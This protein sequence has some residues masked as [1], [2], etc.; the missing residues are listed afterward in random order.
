MA[1]AFK[2]YMHLRQFV[3]SWTRRLYDSSTEAESSA[4]GSSPSALRPRPLGGLSHPQKFMSADLQRRATRLAKDLEQQAGSAAGV[5]FEDVDKVKFY[6][7]GTFLYSALTVAIHPVTVVKIRRQSSL[8]GNLATFRDAFRGLG[9]VLSLAVP[10][11]VLYITTLETTRTGV[12]EYLSKRA[13]QVVARPEEADSLLSLVAMVSSGVAG[14]AAALAAQLLVVPMD[15]VSQKQMVMESKHYAT[16]GGGSI[17]VATGIFRAEGWAGLYR[18]FSLSIFSS[19]P[20]GMMWWSVYGGCQ[21]RLGPYIAAGEGE[22]SMSHLG[23]RTM[24]QIASGMSAAIFAS[25][26]T[27]PFDTVKTRLQ[28]GAQN[29]ALQSYGSVAKKLYASEGVASFWRGTLPRVVHMGVWGTVLSSAYEFLKHV[30]R[31]DAHLQ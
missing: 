27:Q 2:E 23:R 18:G 28:V 14:G 24:V 10:A 7:Y 11:R 25:T 31:M 3:S 13:A 15:V 19:P 9:V 6:G 22:G 1:R 5:R 8:I 17:S 30:S 12:D 4:L 20:T 26:L 29:G 21:T 16:G